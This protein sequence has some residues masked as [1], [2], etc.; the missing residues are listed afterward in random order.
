MRLALH[1]R[2]Y[3][4]L[5]RCDQGGRLYSSG[6]TVLSSAGVIIFDEVEKM[7]PGSL[8]VSIV[9]CKVLLSPQ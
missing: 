3:D 2:I 4:F 6:N 5:D 9:N 1:R 8:D 7:A